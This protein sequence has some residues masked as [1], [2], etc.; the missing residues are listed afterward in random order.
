MKNLFSV[1]AFIAFALPCDPSFGAAG[2]KEATS[3]YVVET[4]GGLVPKDFFYEKKDFVLPSHYSRFDFQKY[5]AALK[6]L[7]DIHTLVSSR[8]RLFAINLS[9]YEFYN[10]EQFSGK[11]DWASKVIPKNERQVGYTYK[12]TKRAEN[13]QLLNERRIV[14][15]SETVLDEIK[16]P[17]Y[18]ALSIWHEILH[19]KIH[20]TDHDR[21]SP[22]IMSMSAALAAVKAQKRGIHRLTDEEYTAFQKIQDIIGE[23]GTLVDRLGGGLIIGANAPG[24]DISMKDNYVSIFSTLSFLAR[25]LRLED[26]H[27]PKVVNMR[28]HLEGNKIIDSSVNFDPATSSGTLLGNTFLTSQLSL[29]LSGSGI[30]METNHVNLST[31]NVGLVNKA[32]ISNNTF[33]KFSGNVSIDSGKYLSNRVKS[34]RF[35]L[36]AWDAIPCTSNDLERV[37]A[38]IDSKEE[39]AAGS[40]E[41]LC[42]GSRNRVSDVGISLSFRDRNQVS[43]LSYTAMVWGI[44][45]RLSLGSGNTVDDL[46][47]DEKKQAIPFDSSMGDGNRLSAIRSDNLNFSLGDDNTLKNVSLRMVTKK[48]YLEALRKWLSD[49]AYERLILGNGSTIIES[50]VSSI[51]S[52][53]V[54]IV[55]NRVNIQVGSFQSHSPVTINRLSLVSPNLFLDLRAK[56]PLLDFNSV[57]PYEPVFSEG[58]TV[59]VETIKD[60]EK[61]LRKQRSFSQS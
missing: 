46:I 6:I 53:S 2:G 61:R 10:T 22:L 43:R 36:K 50:T 16:N 55:L 17:L 15:L 49:R 9:D 28:L 51:L 20:D 56:D 32:E 18:Q 45:P 41:I 54:P 14:E 12:V 4:K 37:I 42:R 35:R 1:I 38:K 23:R 31:L 25:V 26:L 47:I 34:S 33:E 27:S 60:F 5:S 59:K 13:F 30:H 48:G 39:D 8:N 21:I 24:R 52:P 19:F 40:I 58:K 44:Y 3:G 57:S 11:D 7:E 29:S